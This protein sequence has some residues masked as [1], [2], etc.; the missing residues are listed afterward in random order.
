M[1][2]ADYSRYAR[3]DEFRRIEWRAYAGLERLFL[4]VFEAEENLTITILIDCTDSMQHGKPGKAELASALAAALAYIALKCE[5]SV[6]VGPLADKLIAHRRGGSAKHP[7]WTVAQLRNRLPQ[8]AP[9]NWNRALHD[10][11]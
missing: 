5:D 4:R 1:E 10:S 8:A 7:I 2:F 11:G 6:I 3:G 9:T